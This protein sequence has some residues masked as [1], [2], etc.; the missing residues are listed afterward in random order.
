MAG[1]IINLDAELG[2]NI[3]DDDAE[4]TLSLEN[5]NVLGTAL[6][7]KSAGIGLDIVGGGIVTVASIKAISSAASG[8]VLEF[9]TVDF[10]VVS[11]AS[12]GATLAYGVRVKIG[13]TYGWLPVYKD[14][15]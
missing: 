13:N 3:I 8:A 15:A 4:P 7:L 9:G 2:R 1:D 5:T 11:T 10:G 6:K 12:A 14:I